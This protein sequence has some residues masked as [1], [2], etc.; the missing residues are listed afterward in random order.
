MAYP[1]R[2]GRGSAPPAFVAPD[3]ALHNFNERMQKVLRPSTAINDPTQAEAVAVDS[4]A[5][6]ECTIKS[7]NAMA[8][9]SMVTVPTSPKHMAPTLSPAGPSPTHRAMLAQVVEKVVLEEEQISIFLIL[10]LED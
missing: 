8:A 3:L 2:E 10:L 1:L 7:T 5:R 9:A 6:S 4:P